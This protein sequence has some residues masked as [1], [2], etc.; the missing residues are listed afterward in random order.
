IGGGASDELH[1]HSD[2]A[3]RERPATLSVLYAVIISP[4]GGQTWWCN[5]R[6]GYAALPDEIKAEIRE[7]RGTYLPGKM[8]TIDKIEV[9]HPLALA[10]PDGSGHALY[11]SQT[12][13]GILGLAPEKAATLLDTLLRYQLRAGHIYRHE[14]RPGDLMIYDNGQTLHR[15]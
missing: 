5:T 13:R 6:L 9:S 4:K 1:W 15:R 3:F 14:W 7:L 12:T 2:Q 8:H 11:V 10:M